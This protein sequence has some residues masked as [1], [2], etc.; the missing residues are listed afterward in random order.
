MLNLGLCICTK[1]WKRKDLFFYSGE[2][3]IDRY[4]LNHDDLIVCGDFNC[5]IED[6]Y[7]FCYVP[8]IYSIPNY[9]GILY[10]YTCNITILNLHHAPTRGRTGG[11]LIVSQ[12]RYRLNY[13][14]SWAFL[15]LKHVYKLNT[16]F[17]YEKVKTKWIIKWSF[18]TNKKKTR[19]ITWASSDFKESSTRFLN[20]HIWVKRV[21]ELEQNLKVCNGRIRKS[22]YRLKE[23]SMRRISVW[24]YFGRFEKIEESWFFFQC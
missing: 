8:S 7:A 6:S 15:R 3:W 20:T 23:R 19:M 11:L 24:K 10:G 22:T 2:S 5:E 14:R 1:F 21:Q 9:Y 18:L 12:K 4:P 17:N 16:V 13:A